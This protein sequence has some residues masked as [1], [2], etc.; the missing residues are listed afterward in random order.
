MK[1]V[2]YLQNNEFLR[3]NKVKS[4]LKDP[5][6]KE[7]FR[8]QHWIHIVRVVI[9]SLRKGETFSFSVIIACQVCND[10]IWIFQLYFF[11]CSRLY[12]FKVYA[13]CKRAYDGP[14]ISTC[15]RSQHEI[16]P[17]QITNV[18]FSLQQYSHIIACFCLCPNYCS[19]W[20][21][22]VTEHWNE[23]KVSLIFLLYYLFYHIDMLE[24]YTCYLPLLLT[25][26]ACAVFV[27]AVLHT[28]VP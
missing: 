19:T 11:I 5:T 3:I 17:L 25:I 10:T 13:F 28:R 15:T 18:D 22:S 14:K 20:T 21:T 23:V 27:E 2:L 4:K 6:P 8:I 16:K 12:N 9:P 24:K 1:F 26:A 7:F